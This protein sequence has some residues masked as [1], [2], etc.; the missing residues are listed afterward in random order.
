M[1]K[2]PDFCLALQFLSQPM[3]G[4]L[5]AEDDQQVPLFDMALPVSTLFLVSK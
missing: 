3:L 4:L 1:H 5:L 2:I